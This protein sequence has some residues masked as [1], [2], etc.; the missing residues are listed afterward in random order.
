VDRIVDIDLLPVDSDRG[1]DKFK[2]KKLSSLGFLKSTPS[3][4]L[5]ALNPILDRIS[6]QN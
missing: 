3:H 1:D 4:A 5:P 2:T 6:C